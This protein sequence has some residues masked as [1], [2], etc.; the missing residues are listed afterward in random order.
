[1]KLYADEQYPYPVVICLRALGYD[2]L[3]VQEAGKANQRI[4]GW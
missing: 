4:Q 1:M 2:I 3:T